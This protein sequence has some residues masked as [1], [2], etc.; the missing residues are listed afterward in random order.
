MGWVPELPTI[1]QAFGKDGKER[2]YI[3]ANNQFEIEVMLQHAGLM[4]GVIHE[5]DNT[6]LTGYYRILRPVEYRQLKI[7]FP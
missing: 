2:Y 5:Q 3:V 7:S 1:K 6:A 4:I